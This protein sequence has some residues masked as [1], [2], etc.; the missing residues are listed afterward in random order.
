M[1]KKSKN[2]AKIILL[3]ICLTLAFLVLCIM[4]EK[5]PTFADSGFDVSYDSG[6]SSSSSSHD[7]SGNFG[8]N[9][10]TL[11]I[12]GALIVVCVIGT[13]RENR[14]LV[15]EERNAK[16]TSLIIE[17]QLQQ[18]IP[19]FDREHF[20]YDGFRIYCD[21]QM[22]W[23][24]FNL[25]SVR[26][27]LTDEMY[28]MYDSQLETLR[29]KGEQNIMGQFI[30]RGGNLVNYIIQNGTITIT[31]R[32]IIELYDFIIDQKTG[33]VLRG[34]STSK[35]NI[36]YEMMFRKSLNLENNITKCP[37][38]GAPIN[39]NT[40]GVCDYCHTKLVTENTNWVLTDKKVIKQSYSLD[41][42]TG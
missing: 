38:C 37:N 17:N 25:E 16:Q 11:I 3:I 10:T 27:I 21:I 24:N 22:A 35:M 40:S 4:M 5:K 30:P 26:N 34:S 32:Y 20:L 12:M 9:L 31:A 29:V 1:N 13:K 41:D 33:K 6:G 15:E 8:Y 14:K 28:N 23:M 39:M 36:K 7:G 42:L 19:D 2:F 18:I